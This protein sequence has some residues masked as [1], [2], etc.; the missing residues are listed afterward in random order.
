MILQRFTLSKDPE[1]GLKDQLANEKLAVGMSRR[2]AMNNPNFRSNLY[3]FPLSDN[4]YTYSVLIFCRED[5]YLLPHINDLIDRFVEHGFV[6][7]WL[8]ESGDF[9]MIHGIRGPQPLTTDHFLGAL[10]YLAAGHTLALLVFFVEYLM[11]RRPFRFTKA[12]EKTDMIHAKKH[13][14]NKG[15]VHQNTRRYPKA[16][17]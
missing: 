10:I 6:L 12:Y 2:H 4:I 7:K 11:R 9:P 1:S 15:D 14:Q 3:C 13:R 8:K 17:H 16:R 5:F